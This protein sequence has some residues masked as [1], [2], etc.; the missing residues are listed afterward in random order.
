MCRP[1]TDRQLMGV[2]VVLPVSVCVSVHKYMHMCVS[3]CVCVLCMHV[4]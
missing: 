4:V 2:C 3:V 1:A